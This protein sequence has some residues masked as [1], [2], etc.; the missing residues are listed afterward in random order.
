MGEIQEGK[1]MENKHA[2]WKKV[3]TKEGRGVSIEIEGKDGTVLMEKNEVK[4]K[5]REYFSELLGGEET[6]SSMV[7]EDQEGMM[8]GVSNGC[9]KKRSQKKKSEKVSEN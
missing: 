6:V 3:K 1:Y 9:L 8:E 2:F 4:D 5:W 7:E